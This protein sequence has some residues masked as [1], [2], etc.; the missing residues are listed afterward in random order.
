LFVIASNTTAFW[1][2]IFG[3][4]TVTASCADDVIAQT[5]KRQNNIFTIV[6]IS[7]NHFRLGRFVISG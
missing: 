7:G 5:D 2:V 6:L 4:S 1:P 3:G